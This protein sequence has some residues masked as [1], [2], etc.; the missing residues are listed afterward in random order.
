[1]KVATP[2]AAA[3]LVALCLSATGLVGPHNS[4][5]CPGQSPP[6]D[7]PDRVVI[8]FDFQSTFD[9]G[10][11]GRKVG[12]MFWSKL[13]R[14][15]GFILP[16][17]MHDVRDWTKRNELP[18]PDTPLDAVQRAVREGFEG[19]VGIWGRVERAADAVPDVYELSIRIADFS[20]PE[21]RWV[22][23]LDVRTK[24]ASEIPHVYV[25]EAIDRL[26]ERSPGQET[27]VMSDPELERRWHEGRNLVEGDFEAGQQQ[28]S[29]WDP[30][31]RYVTRPA[32]R[33]ER[34]GL[35]HVI[36]FE[37]PE[38]VAANEGV[39]YYSEYFPVEEGATYRFQCRWRS[40]GSAVKVFVKCYDELPTRF[41]QRAS[42]DGS[43]AAERREVYR[44]QQNLKGP[45]KQWNVHTEDFTPNHARFTPRWGRVMLYA[46][47][48]AGFVD[49]DDVVVKQ[50]RPPR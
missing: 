6:P 10:E 41:A 16:E 25:Q 2:R 44:S 49:F 14:Q 32:L 18:S 1:M 43:G 21:P 35:N 47:W 7:A 31:P 45:P 23:R 27:T 38:V 30:L 39:L 50:V 13:H 24:T 3:A 11:Y 46:Y 36:R 17:S 5:T 19:H 48:P 34:S 40:T 37:L 42:K 8:P 15:G 9:Q 33:E 29:G 4:R 28:P 22:C 12:E 20:G 26:Y